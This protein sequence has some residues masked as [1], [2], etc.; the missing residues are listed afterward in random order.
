M[1]ALQLRKKLPTLLQHPIKLLLNPDHV[2]FELGVLFVKLRP[3]DVIARQ[4]EFNTV[5]TGVNM[6]HPAV[7]R[8]EIMPYPPPTMATPAVT[9]A[10][11]TA[12]DLDLFQ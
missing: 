2:L 6:R 7:Q 4:A 10:S 3:S 9:Q 5:E 11:T 8:L 12:S 1:V